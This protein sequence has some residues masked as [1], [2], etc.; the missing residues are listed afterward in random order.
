MPQVLSVLFDH[1][2]R[3]RNDF[4]DSAGFQGKPT[5]LSATCFLEC[6]MT[7]I[8]HR[9]VRPWDVVLNF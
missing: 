5:L 1:G 2:L 6:G 8:G 3:W 7:R 9:H 4:K